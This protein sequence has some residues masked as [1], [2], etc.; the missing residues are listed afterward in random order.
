[1]EPKEVEQWLEVLRDFA[2]ILIAAVLFVSQI[3]WIQPNT[4]LIG[5]GLTLLTAPIAFGL[6][7]R[8]RRTRK[9]DD[10]D[11]DPFDGPGGYYRER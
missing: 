1:M 7:A 5:A 11:D 9:R 3:L 8:R 4:L 6:D 2:S 10:P